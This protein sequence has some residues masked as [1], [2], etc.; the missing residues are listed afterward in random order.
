[1]ASGPRLRGQDLHARGEV[2][3]VRKAVD[4]QEA[5]A[6]QGACAPWTRG[7]N[8]PPVENLNKSGGDLPDIK[9]MDEKELRNISTWARRNGGS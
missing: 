1:M 2:E 3:K 6:D 4:V 9:T 7:N 8:C 5:A